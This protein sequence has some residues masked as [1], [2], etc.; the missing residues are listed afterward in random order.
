MRNLKKYAVY[1]AV[2]ASMF[3]CKKEHLQ[4]GVTTNGAPV[5]SF[6]GLVNGMPVSLQSGINN[7]YMYS[8]YTQDANNVYNFTGALQPVGC[9]GCANTIKITIND[10]KTIPVG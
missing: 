10:Y 3:A 6:T 5:F 1:I 2:A 7:Y 4:Q 8:S 9:N